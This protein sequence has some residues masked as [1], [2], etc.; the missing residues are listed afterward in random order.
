MF[1]FAAGGAVVVSGRSEQLEG[2][3][4]GEGQGNGC[5]EGKGEWGRLSVGEAVVGVFEYLPSMAADQ[6]EEKD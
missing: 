3:E 5:T 2:D 1:S 6:E 4:G